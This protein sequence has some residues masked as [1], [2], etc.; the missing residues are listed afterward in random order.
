MELGDPTR[1]RRLNGRSR[2]RRRRWACWRRLRWPPTKQETAKLL[3]ML[4]VLEEE[5]EEPEE[6]EALRRRREGEEG[7]PRAQA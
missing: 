4:S 3:V 6:V 1:G 2:C 7:N 5:E